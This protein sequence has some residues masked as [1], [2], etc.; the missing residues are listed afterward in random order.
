METILQGGIALIVWLQGLGGWLEIPMKGFSFLGS[1]EFFLIALPVMYWCVNSQA[2]LRIG[3]IVL[4][5]GGLNDIFK[6]ALHG[7][8]PYWYSTQV[9]A[10]AS[11]TSFG[12][13][14]GHA[15]IAVSLWGMA[16]A[17]IKRRWAWAVAVFVMLMIGLS[18]L[19]LAVHFPHDVLLG[20][21]LGLLVL[22]AFM[23]WWEP[24][25]VWANRKSLGQQVG[26]AFAASL[27]MLILGALAFGTLRGW[28]LPAVWLENARL[29]GVEALPAPVTLNNT[30]TSAAVLFG[31]L[32]GLAWM[33]SRGGF[34]SG[35]SFWQRAGR[36]LLGLA[37]V[38]VLYLGLKAVFPRGDEFVPY[39][40]RYVRFALIGLW[41]SAGAPWVFI[42]FHLA[43]KM[44]K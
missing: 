17:Q 6:L 32:A 16:A 19:Y 40:L 28:V 26:L 13:P 20:W 11:E 2:G 9:K 37:G 33:N 30:I 36:L 41:I 15:Q 24:V 18:R 22:W 5:S 12:V 29:A 23:S 44:R 38:L 31:M 14:S 43:Q 7:P 1:E 27:L 4:F 42:R 25:A 10:F 34:D 3:V 21:T 35:G 39:L 8:R